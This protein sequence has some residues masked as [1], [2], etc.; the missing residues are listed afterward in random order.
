VAR[1]SNSVHTIGDMGGYLHSAG[2]P[3]HSQSEMLKLKGKSGSS[4]AIQLANWKSP[5]SRAPNYRW[6]RRAKD[7]LSRPTRIRNAILR[8][9]IMCRSHA[10]SEPSTRM[11]P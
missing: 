4:I 10:S 7:T 6:L 11:I 5:F 8:R 9:H 3:Y 2:N 1:S